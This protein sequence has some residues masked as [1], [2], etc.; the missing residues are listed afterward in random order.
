MWYRDGNCHR[1]G[2]QPA[3][4]RADGSKYWYRDGNLH[5]DDDKPARIYADGT[6]E[7]CRDGKC[8]RDGDKPALILHDGSKYWCRNGVQITEYMAIT[9]KNEL[10]PK[11]FLEI[12]N[13]ETRREFIKIVGIEKI[14]QAL[15]SEIIDKQGDYE[16]HLLDLKGTTGKWPYLKMKNPSIGCW[17]LEAVDKDCKTVDQALEWRNGTKE[18]PTVLT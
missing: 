5:R 13:V 8:H 4:V 2:D 12:Q 6:Q 7:W 1:D 3:I 10:D 18:K 16:L 15:G 9:P 14:Q 11:H 17:H